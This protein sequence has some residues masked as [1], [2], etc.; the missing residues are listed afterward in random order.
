MARVWRGLAVEEGNLQVQVSN[1]RKVLGAAAIETVPGHGYRFVQRVSAIEA[2]AAPSH[3]HN[4]PRELTAFVGREAEVS[5]QQRRLAQTRLL[6]ITG[7]GGLGKS[8]FSLQLA[9]GLVDA[10]ADGV[11]LVELAAVAEPA[12]VTAAF[13]AVLGVSDP[14]GGELREAVA[15]YVRDRELL[16]V[17]DNCEHVLAAVP[18]SRR[19]C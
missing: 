6:T 14:R 11:W 9:A 18:T 13:A 2:A 1:L 15:G 19:S 16:L 12:H 8:R 3:K 4:L 17:V 10:Y 7:A 5:E